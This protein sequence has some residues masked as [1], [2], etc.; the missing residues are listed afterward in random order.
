MWHSCNMTPKLISSSNKLTFGMYE[1]RIMANMLAK[2][3]RVYH[4][5]NVCQLVLL[6]EFFY[7]PKQ[8]EFRT[9]LN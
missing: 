2:S 8:Y 7:R 1:N 5:D 9:L 4:G 6:P 3:L